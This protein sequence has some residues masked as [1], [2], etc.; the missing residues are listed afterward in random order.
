MIYAPV[1]AVACGLGYS[2][3]RVSLRTPS[4]HRPGKRVWSAVKEQTFSPR[5]DAGSCGLLRVVHQSDMRPTRGGD[6]CLT[7]ETWFATSRGL[8]FNSTIGTYAQRE[9]QTRPKPKAEN[10]VWSVRG[11]SVDPYP[12]LSQMSRWTALGGTTMLTMNV[13]PVVGIP[14]HPSCGNTNAA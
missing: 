14:R 2:R 1:C 5:T 9:T 7:K 12:R 3:F 11:H 8:K 4:I 6:E 10:E 13:N